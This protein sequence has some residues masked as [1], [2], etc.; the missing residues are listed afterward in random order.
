MRSLGGSTTLPRA[1]TLAANPGLELKILRQAERNEPV[2]TSD[3]YKD[4]GSWA[5]SRTA[6]H[7]QITGELLGPSTPAEARPVA[8]IFMGLPGAGKTTIGRRVGAAW[9]ASH[10]R[11]PAEATFDPDAV[12]VRLPEYQDG[13]G[14]SVVQAEAVDVAFGDL[15]ER[16]V[17]GR[18]TLFLVPRRRR[19][20]DLTRR[21]VD[22][23]DAAG[24]EV[25]LVL[26]HVGVE[27][28]VARV[29]RRALAPGGRFVPLSYVRSIGSRPRVTFDQL[30]HQSGPLRESQP[31]RSCGPN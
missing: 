12:R 27:T 8:L 14:S 15:Q 4:S 10:G 21:A 28:A 16:L 18:R 6:R 23:L 3:V 20:P 26:V 29:K 22:R 30:R 1:P 9:L 11:P 19:R 31:F 17:G 2:H 5:S 25:H 7:L 24:Y 13:L